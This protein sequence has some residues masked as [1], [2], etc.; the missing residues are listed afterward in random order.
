MVRYL[1]GVLVGST[2]IE[3]NSS[4]PSVIFA[5]FGRLSGKSPSTCKECNF[6]WQAN[7]S[8]W[9]L[10]LACTPIPSGP[11]YLDGSPMSVASICLG[12]KYQ[13]EEWFFFKHWE[14]G[15]DRINLSIGFLWDPRWNSI[16]LLVIYSLSRLLQR[17]KLLDRAGLDLFFIQGP[18]VYCKPSRSNVTEP[19]RLASMAGLLIRFKPEPKYPRARWRDLQ[20]SSISWDSVGPNQI[21][22]SALFPNHADRQ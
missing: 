18:W 6:A 9:M 11:I 20:P 1:S 15:K 4:H 13:K 14:K 2:R 16:E 22:P 12:D 17:F 7:K 8:N 10:H 5:L 3:G 19:F 21:S